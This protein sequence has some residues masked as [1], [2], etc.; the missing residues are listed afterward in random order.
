MHVSIKITCISTNFTIE[1]QMFENNVQSELHECC[2]V[3][4]AIEDLYIY[5][6]IQILVELLF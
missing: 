3:V 5:K 4:W 1:H 2:Y 6:S